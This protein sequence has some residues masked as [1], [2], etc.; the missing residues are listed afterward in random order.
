[1]KMFICNNSKDCDNTKC[2]HHDPHPRFPYSCKRDWCRDQNRIV[3]C[4]P[5]FDDFINEEEMMI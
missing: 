5:I 1:M 2:N 3:K 4:I